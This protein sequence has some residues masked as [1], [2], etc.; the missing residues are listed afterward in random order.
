MN[1]LGWH[2][3][4]RI[5]GRLWMV[6]G[7]ALL[8]AA[9]AL[10]IMMFTVSVRHTP[11]TA[12]E[13]ITMLQ[14]KGMVEA[15][16]APAMQAKQQPRGVFGRFPLLFMAE[17]YLFPFESYLTAPFVKWLPRTALGARIIP[18]FMGL[19]CAVLSL[20]I[21]RRIG[22]WRE[23]WPGVILVLFP[24]SYLL[25]M[26]IAHGLPG[27]P[28][29]MLLVLF[30]FWFMTGT[31]Q[32]TGWVLLVRCA[33]TGLAGGLACSVNLMAMPVLGMALVWVG[34]A[35]HGRR[36]SVAM[37]GILVGAMVGWGPYILAKLLYPGA[38]A[39][40]SATVP[41]AKFWTTL[42]D[43][44]ITF[45]LP[46]VLGF[47]AAHF[48]DTREAVQFFTGTTRFGVAWVALIAM[49]MIV[50]L[51][52]F[53]KESRI[54]RKPVL[55]HGLVFAGVAVMSLIL[56]AMSSRSH[57]FNYRYLLATALVLPFIFA[58]LYVVSNRLMRAVLG[59]IAILIALMNIGYAW[60]LVG[61]W[62]TGEFLD[63]VRLRDL[64]PVVRHLETRQIRHCYASYFDAYRIDYMTDERI[65]AAQP[66][67]ERFPHWPL[68]YRAMVDETEP[69]A[70]V[71]QPDGFRYKSGQFQEALATMG[72]KYR[73][74]QFGAYRV[75]TDFKPPTDISEIHM[76]QKRITVTADAGQPAAGA[77]CDGNRLTRWRSA[78]LQASGM[79][80]EVKLDGLAGVTRVSCYYDGYVHDQPRALTVFVM[81]DG[82]WKTVAAAVPRGLDLFEF[83][84]G[85]PVFGSEGQ[86]IRFAPVLTDHIR[87]EIADADP[88]RAWTMGEIEIFT[89][90]AD[91][92]AAVAP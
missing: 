88:Q 37:A 67:N 80:L 1:S 44:G 35:V 48:A 75:Y 30:A 24:S 45:T 55:N 7:G 50:G 63:R 85:H 74:E 36:V 6:I 84:N 86:T 25:L 66:W 46:T 31:A 20:L 41:L 76:D 65:I 3:F 90:S 91:R 87:I 4:M 13:S 58:W 12:D 14:A 64:A 77:L 70:F 16:D 22:S 5:S 29:F 34:C 62:P 38:F 8:A 61:V 9:L 79:A 32:A 15:A 78:T 73:V 43:P 39:A 26:Q 57:A 71:L 21:L 51:I 72:V 42:W 33:L 69:V 40:V 47:R 59:G 2:G 68:P 27:Y 52:S 28:S 82:K 89:G 19:V 18:A 11:A 81:G 56:F 54:A 10:R 49:T 92:P 60:A 23:V 83:R 53:F 17:P